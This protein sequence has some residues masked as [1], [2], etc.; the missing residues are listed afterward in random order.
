MNKIKQKTDKVNH[1]KLSIFLLKWYDQE[2][3]K[4]PWRIPPELT[5]KG[6]KNDPYKIWISEIML[7]Q[8]GV[9]TV[10]TYY[11]NFINKW[12]KIQNLNDADENDVLREWSGLGYYRRAL[13]LKKC[14][15]IICEDYN[16]KF[17]D[18]EKELLKLPGIGSYTAAAII[19]IAFNK[20]AIVIDGNILRIT[21]RL[22]EI[23]EDIKKSKSEIYRKL[24]KIS[25]KKRPGDFAQALMD[26]GSKICKPVNPKCDSCPL[27]K[28]CLAHKNNTYKSIPMKTKSLN[29]VNRKGY[30]YIGITN[31]EKII[32]IKRPKKGLLGGTICPPTS[33]W[34]KNEF[35]TPKPP[36]KGD[37]KILNESIFHSFTHFDLE[38][39]IM[40]SEI[41][42]YPT[43]VYLE[44]INSI[45]LN[46]LPTVMKKGVELVV[47]NIIN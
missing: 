36:F 34:K 4:L 2:A 45:T 26:L 1:S 7:Q 14:A 41:K 43:N 33:D 27:L 23:K 46:S 9:K 12:P 21:S 8:T 39:K 15:E 35:P 30:L 13:N 38:L 5:K 19:S 47:D 6:I 32:L 31:E 24:E 17:P 37:W 18:I 22:Y 25:S 11:T 16:G 29:K 42:N 10:Q 28:Y 20:P 40:I 44:P 3:R